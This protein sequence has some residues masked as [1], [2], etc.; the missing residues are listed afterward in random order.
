[1][2]QKAAGL[3]LSSPKR[4]ACG[5]DRSCQISTCDLCIHNR[6]SRMQGSADRETVVFVAGIVCV[7]WKSD[8]ANDN[9]QIANDTQMLQCVSYV[10]VDGLRTLTSLSCQTVRI[11]EGHDGREQIG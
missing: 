9:G 3:S 10:D 5:C 7:H 4:V 1:M 6:N 11:A 8:M 2:T